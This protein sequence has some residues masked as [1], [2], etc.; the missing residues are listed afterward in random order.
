MNM[1][2]SGFALLIAGVAFAAYDLVTFRDAMVRNL[3]TQAQIVASNSVTALSF[4][5]PRT[6]EQTLSALEASPDIVLAQIY[7]T[8]GRLFASYW[9]DG[10]TR[11]V[12]PP[13]MPAD[14]AEI[15]SFDAAS[16]DLA[17][18]IVFEGVPT[19]VVRIRS[20]LQAMNDRLRRYALIVAAVLLVSLIGAL[21]VSGVSQR[22]ISR[23]LTAVA[24]AA[25]Q[26]SQQK[27]YSVR[28]PR[29]ETAY[30]LS[31]LVDSFN[32]MLA[33]I[34]ERDRSLQEAQAQLEARV[35]ERTEELHASNS[36]L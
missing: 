3:S 22:A 24:D 21:L 23:P 1:L 36:E 25:R 32:A 8:D 31:V 28:V 26:V 9:R 12:E 14:Q 4:N 11:S 2:V 20:D 15:S 18:R 16:V 29:V 34:Q 30:E 17:R 13:R 5:D 6:A 19:G 7:T 33:E 10:V 27:D 35:R